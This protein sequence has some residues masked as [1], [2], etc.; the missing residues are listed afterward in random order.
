M[1]SINFLWVQ[2]RFR[3]SADLMLDRPLRYGEPVGG[4]S[5]QLVGE[6][7]FST[8]G[9]LNLQAVSAYET[10]RHRDAVFAPP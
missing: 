10:C 2:R 4:F 3:H 1:G 5:G 9:S 7:L 6:T 8:A